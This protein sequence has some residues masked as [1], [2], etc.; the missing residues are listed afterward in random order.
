MVISGSIVLFII[1]IFG[2]DFDGTKYFG[3]S[4]G[5]VHDFKYY[6][7]QGER[8]NWLGIISLFNIAAYVPGFFLFKEK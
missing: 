8:T 2:L 7:I 3:G 5:T 1:T 4:L 6:F